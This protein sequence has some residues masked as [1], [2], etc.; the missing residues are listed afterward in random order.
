[1]KYE[2]VLA[3][4]GLRGNW[5][6]TEGR[7]GW[8]NTTR[9]MEN[10]DGDKL[11]LR[12][13]ETHRDAGKVRFE[14]AVLRALNG[15]GLPFAI[16]CPIVAPDGGTYVRLSDGT[17]RLACAFAYLDGDRPPEREPGAAYAIGEA[18]ARL[19]EGLAAV[20][21]NETPAYPPYYELDRAYPLCTEERMEALCAD[22]PAAFAAEAGR[23]RTL[24]GALRDIRAALPRLRELPH[25]LVHGDLNASNLLG[26]A[27]RVSAVL[28][29]EF[30]TRDARAMEVA[31]LV[32]GYV[33]EASMPSDEEEDAR[34]DAISKP[35]DDDTEAALR[36]AEEALRGFGSRRKLTLAEAEAVPLL[37]RLRKLDV[38]LHFLSRYWDGVDGA[39]VLLAQLRSAERGLARLDRL[40]ERLQR[41]CLTYLT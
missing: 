29:F 24:A 27:D 17:D 2:D 5:S 36:L 34:L 15:S 23:L 1:M 4:F 28:D 8:N 26:T 16:P 13:Y 20:L 38:F 19:S 3:S 30:C 22:P 6:V 31:V 37:V 25:Q 35:A 18:A 10:N 33:D 11:V 7:S 14:H 21:P 32:S 40:G 41:A 12:V 9:Y 39:E